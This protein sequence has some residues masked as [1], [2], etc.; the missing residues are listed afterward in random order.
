MTY[1]GVDSGR[2]RVLTT[3]HRA[4]T[5]NYRHDCELHIELN[6][7]RGCELQRH[8]LIVIRGLSA[9]DLRDMRRVLDDALAALEGD[10]NCD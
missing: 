2:V 8:H 7:L 9:G 1:V 4:G 3:S 6:A 10:G 5:P